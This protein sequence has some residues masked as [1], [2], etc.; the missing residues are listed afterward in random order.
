VF[1]FILRQPNSRFQRNLVDTG[2]VT[3]VV[4]GLVLCALL[5][6]G[7]QRAGA[8]VLGIARGSPFVDGRRRA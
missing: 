2:L 8:R 1:S 3:G 5:A 4:Y 6:A 7:L